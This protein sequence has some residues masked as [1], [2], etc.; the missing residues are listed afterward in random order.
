MLYDDPNYAFCARLV[1]IRLVG[2]NGKAEL[3][4]VIVTNVNRTFLENG[5]Y[6]VLYR[7]IKHIF[8]NVLKIVFVRVYICTTLPFYVNTGQ[9]HSQLSHKMI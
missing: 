8:E 4:F 5:L 9:I 1:K 3:L 7:V 2:P 6:T